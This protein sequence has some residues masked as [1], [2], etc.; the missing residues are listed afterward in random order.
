MSKNE[1]FAAGF[2]QDVTTL[3]EIVDRLRARRTHYTAVDMGST[4]T[5]E[6]TAAQEVTAAQFIDAISSVD[7]FL[8]LFETHKTNLYRVKQ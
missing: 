4:L 6:H 5:N 2:S 8:A 3:I 1:V 7:A